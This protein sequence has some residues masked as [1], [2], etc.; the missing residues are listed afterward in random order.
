MTLRFELFSDHVGRYRFRIIAA[1]GHIVAVSGPYE[2]KASAKSTIAM[3]RTGAP[4]ATI[5]DSTLRPPP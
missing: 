2:S 4:R 3:V 1:N 5:Q